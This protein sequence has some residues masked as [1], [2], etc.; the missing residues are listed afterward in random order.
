MSCNNTVFE[1]RKRLI[2]RHTVTQ[3]FLLHMTYNITL[4]SLV[5]PSLYRRAMRCRYVDKL[6]TGRCWVFLFSRRSRLILKRTLIT[7]R[8]YRV[9]FQRVKRPGH[10]FDHFRLVLS[11]RMSGAIYLRHI[12]LLGEDR[13][14]FTFE[15]KTVGIWIIWPTNM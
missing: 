11:L 5:E 4:C 1:A 14:K 12:R 10:E 13:D 15:P 9:S 3:N 6:G 8:K 7:F 2:I